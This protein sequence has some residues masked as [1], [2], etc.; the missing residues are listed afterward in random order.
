MNQEQ[1]LQLENLHKEENYTELIRLVKTFSVEE[2]DTEVKM[3]LAQAYDGKKNHEA[4]IKT[5]FSI[6]AQG[7]EDVQWNVL[8]GSALHQMEADQAAI[9][10]LVKAQV[11]DPTNTELA[12]FI[13]A[14][15][16]S[17][18]RY[19]RFPCEQC[20]RMLGFS[21]ICYHCRSK[22]QREDIQALTPEE[23]TAKVQHIIEH[24]ETIGDWKE[25]YQD[26]HHLL[27][28]HDISTAEIACAAFEKKIFYPAYL[29]RDA[30]DDIIDNMLEQLKDDDCKIAGELMCCLATK[31]GTTV[32]D[33]FYELEHSPRKWRKKLYVGPSR[34]A[35]Q[36]G[37]TFDEEN[38][39]RELVFDT[40]YAVLPSESGKREDD[41][42][43]L[44]KPR[45]GEIC[46]TCGCQIVD[47]IT[48]DG[49]DERLT[50]L[51]L[52]GT[53]T[54]PACPNCIQF[55]EDYFAPYT[56]DGKSPV[57]V[58]EEGEDENY[59]S[60]DDMEYMQTN[61]LTLSKQ[62]VSLYYSHGCEETV[63]IGGHADWIQDHEFATCP[64]CQKTM[65]LLTAIP[66]ET[67]YENTEGTL[68]IEICKDCQM[69]HMLHQ[70]T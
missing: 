16:K 10:Y 4:A 7:A 42:V 18:S 46:S 37:W 23:V 20:G 48:I 2:L 21:G 5:L 58:I 24:I 36:G 59:I 3:L 56:L 60:D 30:P 44:A 12:D 67:L 53:F 14:C 19:S 27:A 70:Q 66:W 55:A 33:V 26:V 34:Y 17:K 47:M 64:Q 35:W 13:Q 25:V 39:H 68:Y 40:C 51:G 9:P 41:A 63:T 31:G 6:K 38:K 57:I 22:N 62:P 32:Q 52:D 28:Y 1:K 43:I 49:R 29:Y 69:L 61:S 54:A 11:L 8:M 65:M 50:F 15:Q 45:E